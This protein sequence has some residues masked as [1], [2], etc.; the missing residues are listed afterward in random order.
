[1]ASQHR[2]PAWEQEVDTC[3]PPEGAALVVRL[4]D[5]Q[6]TGNLALDCRGYGTDDDGKR[7]FSRH[8]FCAGPKC[9]RQ[10]LPPLT[11]AAAE[12]APS[13]LGSEKYDELIVAE[14][15]KG[16]LE[17]VKVS[18]VRDANGQALLEIRAYV[19]RPGAPA[20]AT[21]KALRL[22]PEVWGAVLPLI[23]TGL[24]KLPDTDADEAA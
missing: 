22:P 19:I 21:K 3:Q 13:A 9:W 14:V 20:T 12:G 6:G 15:R 23:A 17:T 11:A 1:M 10:L 5:W 2:Q 8:G 7:S 4:L 24:A 16:G 18:W